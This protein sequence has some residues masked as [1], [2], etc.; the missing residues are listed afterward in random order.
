MGRAT[1]KKKFRDDGAQLQTV[2]MAV[3]PLHRDSVSVVAN[4]TRGIEYGGCRRRDGANVASNVDNSSVRVVKN[5]RIRLPHGPSTRMEVPK[6]HIGTYSGD[7][8]PGDVAGAKID[9]GD[10][11]DPHGYGEFKTLDGG[12]VSQIIYPSAPPFGPV[13]LGA[14]AVCCLNHP[15]QRAIVLHVPHHPTHGQ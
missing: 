9:H 6:E 11:W 7:V 13:S 8:I 5:M 1:G 3:N 4:S 12:S 15:R 2:A 14:L 10:G